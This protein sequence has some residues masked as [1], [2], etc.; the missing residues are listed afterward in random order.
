MKACIKAIE[1]YL[2]EH[3][4]INE[5]LVKDF[6]EWN[7][8]KVS[9]KT[10][11]LRRCVA[12]ADETAGDMAAKACEKLFSR[13]DIDNDIDHLYMNGGEIFNFTLDTVPALVDSGK[14]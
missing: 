12:E 11:F 14:E 13:N 5:D 9:S 6:P 10:G 1:Y 8:E 7:A 4:L 2:P 3:I